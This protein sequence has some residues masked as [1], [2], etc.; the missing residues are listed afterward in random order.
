MK[1]KIETSLLLDY[2]GGMLTDRQREILRSYC[3]M[4]LSLSEISD[5]YFITRQAAQEIIARSVEK[6]NSYEDKLGLIKKI[7][8]IISLTDEIIL[9]VPDAE[10]KDRLIRLQKEIKEI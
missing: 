2:Y 8:K 10:T 5:E 9:S 7:R 6:L 1:D 3:D 4:D